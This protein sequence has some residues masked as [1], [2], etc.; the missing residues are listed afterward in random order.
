MLWLLNTL[1]LQALLKYII[2]K[3]KCWSVI[4]KR[5]FIARDQYYPLGLK[6]QNNWF[7]S[8]KSNEYEVIMEAISGKFLELIANVSIMMGR[9]IWHTDPDPR[10]PDPQWKVLRVFQSLFASLAICMQIG[11]RQNEKSFKKS[12]NIDM[13]CLISDQRP[14]N[15]SK[16]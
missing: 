4:K 16:L 14:N 5:R 8:H 10:N 7:K 1:Y 3:G 11:R 12:H 2:L 13:N 9:F 15:L 6:L